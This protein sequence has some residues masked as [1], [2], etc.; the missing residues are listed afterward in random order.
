MLPEIDMLFFG[1]EI[2]IFIT[3]D[4]KR[5]VSYYYKG[6]IHALAMESVPIS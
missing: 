5:S 6:C 2:E 1:E 3:V 4:V